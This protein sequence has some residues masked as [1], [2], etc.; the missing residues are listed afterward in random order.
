MISHEIYFLDNPQTAQLKDA[1]RKARSDLAA[2]EIR[3]EGVCESDLRFN[4]MC[5][6]Q[7]TEMLRLRKEIAELK[8]DPVYLRP[9]DA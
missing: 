7:I 8:G 3:Y 9:D 2:L 1:L 5:A 4:K 6:E